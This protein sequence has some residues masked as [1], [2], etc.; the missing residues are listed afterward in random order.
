MTFSRLLPLVLALNLTSCRTN[1]AG[2]LAVDESVFSGTPLVT[3][4]GEVLLVG[5]SLTLELRLP[6]SPASYSSRSSVTLGGLAFEYQGG[7]EARTRAK[8]SALINGVETRES[9]E[10]LTDSDDLKL[11]RSKRGRA[12]FIE[13]YN[14]ANAEEFRCSKSDNALLIRIA[15]TD[16]TLRVDANCFKLTRAA[17]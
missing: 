1:S 16:E 12:E 15:D 13:Q 8:R 10:I 11:M 7:S 6:E 4:Q 9:L 3:L 17:R 14:I 5:K 2:E